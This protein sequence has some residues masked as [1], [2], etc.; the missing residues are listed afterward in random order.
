MTGEIFKGCASCHLA[1]GLGNLEVLKLLL[2]IGIDNEATSTR[3]FSTTPLCYALQGLHQETLDHVL[4]APIDVT[5]THYHGLANVAGD[6]DLTI[7]FLVD[8]SAVS[9]VEQVLLPIIT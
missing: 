9:R 5:S 7:Q 2:E 3:Q 8:S 1:C 4:H 6:R